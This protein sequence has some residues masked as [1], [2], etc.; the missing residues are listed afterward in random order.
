[1][2]RDA[3]IAPTVDTSAKSFY[4]S[5]Q[6]STSLLKIWPFGAEYWREKDDTPVTRVKMG[7]VKMGR[8]VSLI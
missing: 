1:M 7:R 3:Q 5:K 2:T 4:I 6:G 8:A